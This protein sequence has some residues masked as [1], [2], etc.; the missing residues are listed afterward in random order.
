MSFDIDLIIPDED[1]YQIV[2]VE[3]HEEGAVTALGGDTN[4]TTNITY[5]YS[6][7]FY[8]FI[9]E[10]DGIRVLDG[11]RAGDWIETLEEVV[12]ILGTK[13]WERGEG[14]WAP[15]PGN[16]GRSLKPLLEWAKQHPDAEF[17]V[18]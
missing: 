18:T 14:Y 12:E 4:A 16:A 5:N 2:Q 13:E 17:K 11:E 7:F 1:D 10:D 6:W 15:T 3:N 9:D 8:Q